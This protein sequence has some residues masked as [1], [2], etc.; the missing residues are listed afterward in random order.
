M[1]QTKLVAG[2]DGILNTDTVT[3]RVMNTDT[4]TTRI[5]NT[6]TVTTRL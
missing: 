1:N 3:T 5:M 6:D 2:A 4:V